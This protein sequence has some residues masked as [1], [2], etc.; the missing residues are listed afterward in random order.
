MYHISLVYFRDFLINPI[1]FSVTFKIYKLKFECQCLLI[2]NP[3]GRKN[4]KNCTEKQEKVKNFPKKYFNNIQVQL[5]ASFER[6][7]FF[8]FQIKFQSFISDFFKINET[9]SSI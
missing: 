9:R 6:A 7:N 8:E 4:Q 2:E 1:D 3:F 5:F